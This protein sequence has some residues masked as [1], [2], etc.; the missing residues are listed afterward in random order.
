MLPMILQS[1]RPRFLGSTQKSPTHSQL[2][3]ISASGSIPKDLILSISDT[4]SMYAALHPV[5]NIHAIFV[6][7]LTQCDAISVPVVS[8][9]RVVKTTGKFYFTPSAFKS[10]QQSIIAP[11]YFAR[12]FRNI[13]ATSF[14]SVLGAPKPFVQRMSTPWSIL[15]CLHAVGPNACHVMNIEPYSRAR[16]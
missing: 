4:F 10:L 1:S 7:L 8:L 13:S 16:I 11:T 14:P 5:P 12:D 2:M 9:I 3:A 6:W 15:S